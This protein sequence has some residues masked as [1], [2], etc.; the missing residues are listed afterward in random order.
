MFDFLALGKK[1]ERVV[2]PK[3]DSDT[4]DVNNESTKEYVHIVIYCKGKSFACIN[5]NRDYMDGRKKKIRLQPLIDV[6][7][8]GFWHYGNSVEYPFDIK[9]S[10]IYKYWISE[11]NRMW[12]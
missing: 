7:L 8:E 4:Y 1:L 12:Y 5:I 11:I 10:K 3:W 2:K 6:D 9:P